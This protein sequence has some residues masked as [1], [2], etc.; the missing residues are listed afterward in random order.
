MANID[1]ATPPSGVG[2]TLVQASG[3]RASLS[4]PTFV[5]LTPANYAALAASGIIDANT[6]YIVKE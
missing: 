1:L 6:V 5:M 2:P 4:I 3:I